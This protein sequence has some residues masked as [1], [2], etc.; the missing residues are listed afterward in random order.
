ML[1]FGVSAVHLFA[2]LAVEMMTCRSRLFARPENSDP[3]RGDKGQYFPAMSQY[4]GSDVDDTIDEYEMADM[5]DEFP[6]RRMEYSESDDE[7]YEQSIGRI[8][9]TTAAQARKG[10][11]IQGIPWDGLNITREQYR[12]TRLEQYKNYENIPNSGEASK[13]G[14]K[15]TEK[16]GNYYEF[17][18][19]SRSV[20]STILHFQV[21]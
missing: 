6:R 4:E 17:S 11:D 14:C 8:T 13:K 1:Q 20:K 18:R 9:D 2:Q 12:Q 16:C 19:N 21:S 15:T 5:D 10:K 7:E 3:L